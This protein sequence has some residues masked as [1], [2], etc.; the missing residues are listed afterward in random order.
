MKPGLF[1]LAELLAWFIFSLFLSNE[2]KWKEKEKEIVQELQL[3]KKTSY[4][5]DCKMAHRTALLQV[6]FSLLTV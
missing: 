2:K 6:F 1:F 4:E 3:K 5:T